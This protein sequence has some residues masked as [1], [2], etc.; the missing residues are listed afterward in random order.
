[1]ALR[2]GLVESAWWASPV[3]P[4]DG[5]RIAKEI[6]FDTYD[7]IPMEPLTPQQVRSIR[8]TS[9]EVGME[10]SAF[11]AAGV[12]LPDLNREVRTFTVGWLNKQLDIGY[13]LGCTSMVLGTGEYYYEKQELK[14]ELQWQWLVEGVRK[15]GEHAETL[16]MTV[17]LET[18]AHKHGILNS[19][20]LLKTFLDDVGNPA[21]KGN[22]DFAHL[23]LNGDTPDSLRRLGG[24]VGHV[25]LT[26]CKKGVHG[27]MPAGRGDVPV[28]EYLRSLK[29][30]GFGGDVA[31]ELEWCPEPQK[32]LEW[33]KEA[34]AS[35]SAMMKELAIIR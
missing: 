17:S 6:G 4:L 21:I 32:A 20:D 7:L 2:L 23:F 26:D 34:Y 28:R 13:D 12:S 15:I 22:A 16:G 9:L 24:R 33:V 29:D 8:G 30:I 31:V 14:P 11:T 3:D 18:L 1:V 19:V 27:D 5:I 35:T 25:H 10:F